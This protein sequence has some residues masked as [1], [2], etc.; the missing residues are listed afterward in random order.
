MGGVQTK[1]FPFF[2]LATSNVLDWF[3]SPAHSG[4]GKMLKL[5]VPVWLV[6][7][8]L[9]RLK[10]WTNFKIKGVSFTHALCWGCPGSPG[11]Q[12]FPWWLRNLPAPTLWL[13]HLNRWLPTGKRDLSLHNSE[14]KCLTRLTESWPMDSAFITFFDIL[15]LMGFFA[16]I[17]ILLNISLKQSS[18][19]LS[20]FGNPLNLVSKASASLASPSCQPSI[21]WRMFLDQQPVVGYVAVDSDFWSFFLFHH[22]FQLCLRLAFGKRLSLGAQK[23]LYI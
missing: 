6:K 4:T 3:A 18:W 22:P 1:W 13:H 9:V 2:P 23:L 17:F 14:S 11:Q 15:F 7:I 19:L 10:W 21:G 16:F 8:G 20:F 5:L 12:M